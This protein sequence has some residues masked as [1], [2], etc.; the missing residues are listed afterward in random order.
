MKIYPRAIETRAHGDEKVM[1]ND[2]ASVLCIIMV[3]DGPGG[4]YA[5]LEYPRVMTSGLL[6]W[7][8]ARFAVSPPFALWR[9]EGGAHEWEDVG[10]LKVDTVYTSGGNRTLS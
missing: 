6:R 7:G 10:R 4:N 9:F 2:G 1:I 3:F 8:S 5:G